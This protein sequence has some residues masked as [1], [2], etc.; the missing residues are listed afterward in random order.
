[1]EQ[2]R[3]TMIEWADSLDKLHIGAEV[4]QFKTA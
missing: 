4:I 2:R 1:M 3:K